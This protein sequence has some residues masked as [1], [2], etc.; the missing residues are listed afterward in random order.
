MRCPG[1][2]WLVRKDVCVDG[3][4]KRRPL[5]CLFHFSYFYFRK[6]M[7]QTSRG[8]AGTGRHMTKRVDEWH[9]ERKRYVLI[10]SVF[11]WLN[12]LIIIENSLA[13][14]LLNF[15]WFF[16]LHPTITHGTQD[17]AASTENS[18]TL[19]TMFF[20]IT[21]FSHLWLFQYQPTISLLEVRLGS[22]VIFPFH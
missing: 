10:N 6:G 5:I 16:Y 21:L 2:F 4:Q 11:S 13:Y 18:V 19:T 8:I 20:Y 17:F 3:G 22:K 12:I 14:M 9:T 7:L 1:D 15:I